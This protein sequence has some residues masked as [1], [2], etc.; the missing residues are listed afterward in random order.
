MKKILIL[1]VLATISSCFL[2]SSIHA[3]YKNKKVIQQKQTS[4]LPL[5][6]AL[7]FT[8]RNLEQK[9]TR[10]LNNGHNPTALDEQGQTALHLA[11]I[12]DKQDAIK[13][14]IKRG[15]PLETPNTQGETPLCTAFRT[16]KSY[17]AAILL[18][19]KAGA[20]LLA[21]PWALKKRCYQKCYYDTAL[22]ELQE[23]IN[24]NNQKAIDRV[25]INCMYN[26]FEKV[27][28]HGSAHALERCIEKTKNQQT[29]F[30][31]LDMRYWREIAFTLALE[32]QKIEH[33]QVVFSLYQFCT[34]GLLNQYKDALRLN[35]THSALY[36]ANILT[37]R[38][39]DNINDLILLA[40]TY[41]YHAG[42]ELRKKLIEQGKIDI[43][44]SLSSPNAYA[45]DSYDPGL[46]DL[47]RAAN[48]PHDSQSKK[49]SMQE[50]I[51]D[52]AW[53]LQH[54]ANPN[55][56]SRNND[57]NTPLHMVLADPR[58]AQSG[59]K[60]AFLLLSYG[61]ARTL[62]NKNGKTPFD[63]AN[64][65]LDQSGHLKELS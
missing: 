15:I 54:G 11:V 59:Y 38:T 14:F 46:T 3:A 61:A 24:K 36:L 53:F 48:L 39:A 17:G 44:Q 50:S 37:N 30:S 33:A 20:S 52:I 21:V 8:T 45:P 56:A 58:E 42:K 65:P 35:K 22:L 26:D 16:Q 60:R 64:P 55:I 27:I 1:N 29:G 12:L 32:Q 47:F 31:G 19:S 2:N 49:E 10:L 5:H 40:N 9:L 18:L 28:Q 6:N 34:N 4:T 51:D 13:L 41:N 23:A 62:K 25:L 7:R 57:N 63:V 43:N